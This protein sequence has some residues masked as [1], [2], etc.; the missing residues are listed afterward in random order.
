MW[1]LQDNSHLSMRGSWQQ[2][3]WHRF[4]V[5]GQKFHQSCL[6]SLESPPNV[7]LHT[8]QPDC[9]LITELLLSV[10]QVRSGGMVCL[11]AQIECIQL[12]LQWWVWFYRMYLHWQEK[13]KDV[14]STDR[15][16]WVGPECTSECLP[17]K[18]DPEITA[19]LTVLYNDM[20]H[21]VFYG[22]F[23]PIATWMSSMRLILKFF[24]KSWSISSAV[25][26]TTS[27]FCSRMRMGL[28]Q[29]WLEVQVVVLPVT[30]SLHWHCQY[31]Y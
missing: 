3:E 10:V 11:K 1:G 18:E 7:F 25:G 20:L 26:T 21:A 9:M 15:N 5:H 19:R 31:V 24:H 17:I 22:W 12:T 2:M 23:G 8:H 14:H 4:S 27:D 6:L 30:V 29:M 16:G 13:L 28:D